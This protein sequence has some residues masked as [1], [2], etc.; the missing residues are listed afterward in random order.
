MCLHFDTIF[1]FLCFEHF[2]RDLK[3]VVKVL[4]N[5]VVVCVYENAPITVREIICLQ[6]QGNVPLNDV[7]ERQQMNGL[8]KGFIFL[9]IFS[10]F[11]F[12]ISFL[13]K[14]ESSN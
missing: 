14:I 2:L 9:F 4:H 8:M 12:F 13:F 6:Q 5:C 11:L 1:L 10:L 3:D 7:N